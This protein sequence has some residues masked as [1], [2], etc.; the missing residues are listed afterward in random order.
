LL[1]QGAEAGRARRRRERSET[2]QT[3]GSCILG[4]WNSEPGVNGSSVAFQWEQA[5]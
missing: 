5:L 2:R 1:G 3:P 4:E